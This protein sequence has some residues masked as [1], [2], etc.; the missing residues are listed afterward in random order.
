M[1]KPIIDRR[2]I[3]SLRTDPLS[4]TRGP[5]QQ[6]TQ[7]TDQL[8]L[9]RLLRK[10]RSKAYLDA[11][12]KLDAGGHVQNQD[13]IKEI[14]YDIKN[15][16]PEVVL[17]NFLGIVA[18]C[19]LG[20]PYEVHTLDFTGDILQHY[21]AGQTLPGRLEKARSLALRGGYE[22][23]EVYDDCCRAVSSN[24]AVSVIPG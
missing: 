11:V 8:R 13:Q 24:G 16:L 6:T 10:R 15:E 21:K 9:E 12:H 1:P 7:K 5:Q 3:S 22:F 4:T 23:I 14:M 2:Q 19:N 18:I 17:P 20:V